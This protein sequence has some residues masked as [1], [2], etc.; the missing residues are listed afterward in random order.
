MA[1]SFLKK[2]DPFL[3]SSLYGG[4]DFSLP[5]RPQGFSFEI[6]FDQK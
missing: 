5:D 2:A 4:L 6:T 1:L 3:S